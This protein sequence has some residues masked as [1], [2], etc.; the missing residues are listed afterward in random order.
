MSIPGICV[1]KITN[2]S[3]LKILSLIT[4]T[5]FITIHSHFSAALKWIKCGN[6]LHNHWSKTLTGSIKCKEFFEL[7]KSLQKVDLYQR[8]FNSMKCRNVILDILI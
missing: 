5:V 4:Y 6:T 2:Y 7:S 8:N 1:E 3:E